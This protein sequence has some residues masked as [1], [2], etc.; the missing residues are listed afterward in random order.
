MKDWRKPKELARNRMLLLAFTVMTSAFTFIHTG[1]S[2]TP[3]PESGIIVAVQEH[4]KKKDSPDG[5]CYSAFHNDM[6][7]CLFS[8]MG[9]LQE[10]RVVEIGEPKEEPV[11]GIAAYHDITVWPVKAELRLECR[12][13]GRVR[14]LSK[15]EEYKISFTDSDGGHWYVREL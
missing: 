2:K 3:P 14:Q 5:M 13:Q 10:I 9:T 15:T 8:R 11:K 7:E 4:F 1:C 12:C 6:A